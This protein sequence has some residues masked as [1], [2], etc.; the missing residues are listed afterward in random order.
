MR[1]AV[2]YSFRYYARSYRFVAPLLM[3]GI[4]LLFIYGVVPNP[5]MS[6]YSLTSTMLFVVAAWLGFGY[7]DAED[8]TQQ[9]ITVMHIGN[10]IKYY[11]YKL[12][13]IMLICMVLSFI[14]VLYPIA[15]D[16]FDR[17][18]SLSESV[19]A[20]LSHGFLALLGLSISILFTNKLVGKLSYA[21][22]GIFLT[23]AIAL[24]GAGIAKALPEYASG[25]A[26]LLPPLFRTMETL[27]RYEE[28]TALDIALSVTAPLLYSGILLGIF[29]VSMKKRLF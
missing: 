15:F 20:Y 2:G 21:I 22:L 7:I 9:L 29:L 6:S 19:I 24:A 18:P 12:M 16:K 1:A 26:W 14:C 17:Q 27:N 5:V 8:E 4:I 25:L 11:L 10:V 23:I 28:A 13:V 3:F